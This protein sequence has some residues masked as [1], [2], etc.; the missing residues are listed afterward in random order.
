M[1][2][3]LFRVSYT[4]AGISGVLKEGAK[5]RSAA[6]KKAVGSVGGRIESGYWAFGE[7]DYVLIADLPDNAAA[8]ALSSSVGASGGA[9][10]STTVLL[11][12]EEVDAGR[13]LTPQYRAPGT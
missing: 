3:Y 13:K 8:I 9:R 6:I 1:G 10:V 11:T 7:D 12:A 2:K 5:G 4:Q